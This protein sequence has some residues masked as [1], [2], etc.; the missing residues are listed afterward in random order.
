MRSLTLAGFQLVGQGEHPLV[1][2]LEFGV[3]FGQDDNL[4]PPVLGMG[5]PLL[6]TRQRKPSSRKGQ[7]SQTVAPFLLSPGDK[8]NIL[9]IL[10]L[11][12]QKAYK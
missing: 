2:D 6:K 1:F 11:L 8:L 10:A 5:R 7:T 4:R 3:Q 12:A 9:S